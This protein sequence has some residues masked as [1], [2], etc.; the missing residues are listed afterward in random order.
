MNKVLTFIIIMCFTT[1]VFASSSNYP[2]TKEEKRIDEM[3]SLVGSG[4]VSF[5]PKVVKV[6]NES[7]KAAVAGNTNKY[8]WQAAI[9]ELSFAPL[10]SVDS[11][12]G[13]ILTDWYTPEDKPKLNYKINVFIKSDVISIDSIEVKV[14]ENN[15]SKNNKSSEETSKL[16]HDLENKILQ[17][18]RNLYIKENRKE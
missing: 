3:G 11:A 7:T 13:V 14:F 5:K 2:K 4:G 1:Q 16:A 9:E 18:A 17:K 10:A 15:A 6:K 12:G 8:L